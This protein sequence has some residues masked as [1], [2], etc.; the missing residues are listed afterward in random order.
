M[1]TICFINSFSTAKG[2]VAVI[3]TK[4]ILLLTL[5]TCVSTAILGCLSITLVIT[6][7]VLRPTPGRVINCSTIKGTSPL[8][9]SNN[10]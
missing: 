9:L 8:K 6:F 10:I 2:V 4:P 1:L 7:A 3:G 5:N